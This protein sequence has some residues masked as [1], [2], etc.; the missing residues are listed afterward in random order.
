MHVLESKERKKTGRM[1]KIEN[2]KILISRREKKT[3]KKG[4]KQATHLPSRA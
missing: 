4:D 3:G 1:R 2:A